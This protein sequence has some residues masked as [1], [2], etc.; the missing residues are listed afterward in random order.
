MLKL[1]SSRACAF[2][3]LDY[4]AEVTLVTKLPDAAESIRARV[5]TPS[6]GITTGGGYAIRDPQKRL[7]IVIDIN[8]LYCQMIGLGD[9]QENLANYTAM[10]GAALGRLDVK[11]LKRIGFKAVVFL[12]LQMTHAEMVAL[13][14]GSYFAPSSEFAEI[15]G[16]P[17]DGLLQLHGSRAGMKLVLTL[18]PQTAEQAGTS[19]M[20]MPNLAQFLEPQLLD[21]GVKD[22]KERIAQ[23]CLHVDVDLH[24]EDVAIGDV[25]SFLRTSL[26][27]ADTV[28]EAAVLKLKSLRSK[29]GY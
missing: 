9:W 10:I 23:E 24:R 16:K 3:A 7:I 28:V 4:Q 1:N 17:G 8:R 11:R 12:P 19:F 15:C 21:A 6:W 22:F 5:G 27:Q 25:Q 14:F 26:D 2:L 13:F 29:R 20:T 18:A